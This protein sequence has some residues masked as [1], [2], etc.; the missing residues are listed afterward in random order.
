M[1]ITDFST[2]GFCV[3]TKCHNARFDMFCKNIY[4]SVKSYVKIRA[5]QFYSEHLWRQRLILVE[6]GTRRYLI[7]SIQ[8]GE[9]LIL[10]TG[11]WIHQFMRPEKHWL[12]MK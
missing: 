2:N 11:A 5:F 8:Q 4:V 1:N 6:F 9:K 7:S 12:R 3:E 10:Y